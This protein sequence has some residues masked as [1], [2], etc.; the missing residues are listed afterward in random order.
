TEVTNAQYRAFLAAV[1]AQ[2]DEAWRHPDQPKGWDHAPMSATWGDAKWN[3]DGLPV[4][5]VSYWDA[6]AFAKWSGRRL[7][8]EAE[9][10][11]AAAKSTAKGEVELRQWPPFC[12]GEEWR[13]GVLATSESVKGPV[14]ADGPVTQGGVDDVSPAG[15]LHMG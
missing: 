15:C 12:G 14:P 5:G 6:C 8:T 2:G 7:P 1:K 4:V 3:A 11:K 9:W 10:V 13:D